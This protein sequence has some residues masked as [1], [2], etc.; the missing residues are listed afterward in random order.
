MKLLSIILVIFLIIILL[1]FRYRTYVFSKWGGVL[2]LRVIIHSFL[3]ALI[4]L[5]VY[6]S[7]KMEE[8]SIV[9][10][11]TLSAT[12]GAFLF[13][14][15]PFCLKFFKTII[16]VL[17]L[18]LISIFSSLVALYSDINSVL[19]EYCIELSVG[20]ILLLFLEFFF[21]ER[22]KAMKQRLI[23]EYTELIKSIK[24]QRA[25]QLEYERLK[26]EA[27]L[28]L[29]RKEDAED[30]EYAVHDYFGIPRPLNIMQNPDNSDEV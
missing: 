21:K 12:F 23:A 9:Q 4:G 28:E 10:K 22:N 29:I 13:W 25:E 2:V 8:N 17:T 6:Y 11:L 30:Y 7:F 24:N 5:G 27:A 19:K 14:I 18:L 1:I 26:N 3:L 20:I 15:T 16:G